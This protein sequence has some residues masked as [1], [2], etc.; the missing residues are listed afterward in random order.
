MNGGHGLLMT[1]WK[2]FEF[3][4]Y[5]MLSNSVVILIFKKAAFE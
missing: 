3:E 1:F 2:M 5:Q 4:I